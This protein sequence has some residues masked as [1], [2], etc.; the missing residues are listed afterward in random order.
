VHDVTV[1]FAFLPP[2]A[3]AALLPRVLEQ[4]P[5]GGRFVTHEQLAGEWPIAPTRTE[6]VV[7]GAITVASVWEDDSSGKLRPSSARRGR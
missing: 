4:M 2:D 5:P 1:A 3:V 7:T 6:L